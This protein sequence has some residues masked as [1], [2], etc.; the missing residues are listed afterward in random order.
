MKQSRIMI[1]GAH[2]FVGARALRQYPAAIPVPG[3]LLR[4][5]GEPLARFVKE[6]NP[7][8]ILNT[9]AISD[10]GACEHNPE[11]SYAANVILPEVLAK[12][13]AEIGAKLVSFSSDQ[14]YTGCQ[15]E[16]PYSEDIVLPAP[17][18]V[19]ARHK[20]EAERRVLEICPD[21]VMLRATWMYD[22][23]MY[24]PAVDKNRKSGH[25][26]RGN[27][28]MNVLH[29]VLQGEKMC[30][31]PWEYRG[32][33]YVRQVVSLLEEISHLP[34]GVYNYGSENEFS[35]YDTAAA[36]LELLQ[37]KGH[38]RKTDR[39]RHN[40]WM[41]CGKIK[42]K[43]VEFDTTVEGF[44]RCVEDYGLLTWMGSDPLFSYRRGIGL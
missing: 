13:A 43:R 40:L 6:H 18:N 19:Y 34:G 28:L 3:D 42:S 7:G 31:S 30:F 11:A 2:G 5:A 9:A 22:M 33:T 39:K 8:I 21:A 15:D 4:N 26:N 29:A 32:I 24:M 14:V 12:T 17:A 23:P 25:A 37:L 41:D 44:R 16:G 10:I 36:L 1:T 35:M 20:L 38:L 27:F